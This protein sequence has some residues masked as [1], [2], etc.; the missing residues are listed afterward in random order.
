MTQVSRCRTILDLF[1][2]RGMV[3]ERR[4]LMLPFSTTCSRMDHAMLWL[5]NFPVETC[6]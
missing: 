4:H 1:R 3:D 5:R 2:S 6:H